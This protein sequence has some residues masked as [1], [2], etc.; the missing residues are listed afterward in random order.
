MIEIANLSKHYTLK[1]KVVDALDD[2][3]L[4]IDD[5]KI[6]GIIGYSGA[7]KST[8]VRC[9]N[10]LEKPDTG[11]VKID[12]DILC[13]YQTS[14][15]EK[16][17]YLK[18]SKLNKVRK[19]IGMIFQH[20]NLLDRSTVAENIEYTLKYSRMSKEDRRQRVLEL[21]NIVDLAD[22]A[23]AYPS[24][25]SGGQKQRVSIARAIANNPKILLSDEAT[26]ALD[27]DATKS[28]LELL[29]KLNK[30]LG[31]T[32]VVITHEMDVVKEICDSV[33][34][35][36][37]GKIVEEGSVYDIFA[38]PKENITKKFVKSSINEDNLYDII[39]SSAVSFSKNGKIVRLTFD[40]HCVG[41][42]LISKVSKCFEINVN[43]LLANVEII[44]EKSLGTM[45]CKING[46]TKEI[47]KAINELKDNNVSVEVL[48]E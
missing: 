40:D 37:N 45:I 18:G 9:I 38:H 31:I 19:N 26:S 3:S 13:E 15:K 47:D 44:T 23:D 11:L 16:E 10:L 42:A 17:V 7:G 21:L 20:F 24:Q 1:D 5:G 34:V 36:E 27:P 28:I 32:I 35:M 33:A 41:E 22:K 8:L 48:Y 30:Q 43:I 6:Y 46:E 14:P 12:D 2:V 25:L 29:K 4:K 39:Q